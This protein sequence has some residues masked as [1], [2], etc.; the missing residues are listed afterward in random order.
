MRGVGDAA[1]YGVFDA[2]RETAAKPSAR[3][4]GHVCK[5]NV[6]PLRVIIAQS[7]VLSS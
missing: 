7:R 3:M 6:R 1:P 4:G 2:G 5:A